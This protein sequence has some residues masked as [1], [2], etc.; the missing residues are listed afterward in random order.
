MDSLFSENV[1]HFVSRKTRRIRDRLSRSERI[2]LTSVSPSDSYLSDTSNLLMHGDAI[3]KLKLLPSGFVHTLLASKRLWSTQSDRRRGVAGEVYRPYRRSI[4]RGSESPARR[5]HSLAEPRRHIPQR[6][7]HG[8]W[9]SSPTRLEA[10]QAIGIDA[11][12]SCYG[13][14]SRRMVG[15]ECVNMAQAECN[16]GECGRQTLERLGA[17]LPA[18]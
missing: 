12:P 7:W 6:N 11:V 9:P 1:T 5:R 10:Q 8:R 16:A 18:C 17:S 15:T 3:S 4:F 14:R 13:T 2:C